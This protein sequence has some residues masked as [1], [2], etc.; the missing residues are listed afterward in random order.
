MKPDI[1]PDT[2]YKKGRISGT[3]Y[4]RNIDFL[5]SNYFLRTFI[6]IDFVIDQFFHYSGTENLG[7]LFYKPLKH[8][9]GSAAFCLVHH[10]KSPKSLISLSLK[11]AP[12]SRYCN[13]SQKIMVG[14]RCYI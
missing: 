1:R 11:W 13:G 14:K 10:V 5:G 7:N 3:T 6:N 2:G 12:L 8:A 4:K 9:N